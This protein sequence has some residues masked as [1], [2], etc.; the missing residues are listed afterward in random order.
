M[1]GTLRDMCNGGAF[2]TQ[3]MLSCCHKKSTLAIAMMKSLVIYILRDG[4]GRIMYCGHTHDTAI[5]ITGRDDLQNFPILAVLHGFLQSH[6][7]PR[8]T[9]VFSPAIPGLLY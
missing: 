1:D 4:M 6:Q 5:Y 7:N 9:G 3:M 2:K 8:S